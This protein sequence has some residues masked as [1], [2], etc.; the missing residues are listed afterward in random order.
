VLNRDQA[1]FSDQ[2]TEL[3][4][5]EIVRRRSCQLSMSPRRLPF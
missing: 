1:G 5:I 4:G 2:I 3:K